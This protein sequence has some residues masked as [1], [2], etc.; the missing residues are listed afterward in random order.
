MDS[1]IYV[2]FVPNEPRVSTILYDVMCNKIHSMNFAQICLARC[3]DCLSTL[4]S[5]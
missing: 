1:V 5:P 4:N 3:I 2:S